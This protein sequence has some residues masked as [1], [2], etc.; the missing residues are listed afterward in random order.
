MSPSPSSNSATS[1]SP[2]PTLS[3]TNPSSTTH[4]TD[5]TPLQPQQ[6]L[7]FAAKLSSER[8]DSHLPN[9]QCRTNSDL[10]LVSISELSQTE[11]SDVSPTGHIKNV[12]PNLNQSIDSLRLSLSTLKSQHLSL[13]YSLKQYLGEDFMKELMNYFIERVNGKLRRQKGRYETKMKELEEALQEIRQLKERMGQ[14]EGDL[15]ASKAR[16]GELSHKNDVLDREMNGLEEQKAKEHDELQKTH[17]NYIDDLEKSHEAALEELKSKHLSEIQKM[18]EESDTLRNQI[19]EQ[20]K[21]HIASLASQK[22]NA[23]QS[24]E[25]ALE[26]NEKQARQQQEQA[27]SDAKLEWERTTL[28][29]SLDQINSLEETI[30]QHEI[31]LQDTKDMVTAI[32]EEQQTREIEHQEQLEQLQLRNS[33]LEESISKLEQKV[34]EQE[35]LIAKDARIS[36]IL[37][38]H[39]KALHSLRSQRNKWRRKCT[40]TDVIAQESSAKMEVLRQHNEKLIH[41]LQNHDISLNIIDENLVET[42]SDTIAILN[43]IISKLNTEVETL[44]RQK[45]KQWTMF[46]SKD[47][48]L[49]RV[50]ER[51]LGSLRKE[52]HRLREGTLLGNDSNIERTM[53]AV[54]EEKYRTSV[55]RIKKLETDMAHMKENRHED[56]RM[57]IQ[58]ITTKYRGKIEKLEAQL[59]ARGGEEKDK[60][61]QEKDAMIAFLNTKYSR[62]ERDYSK[63]VDELV[64]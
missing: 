14:I 57:A 53:L 10:S 1:T 6:T 59:G 38:R 40:E 33:E 41:L 54:F 45:K 64:R 43:R 30:A 24:L 29:P 58:R 15:E 16:E 44:E 52:I 20:Q 61:I 34:A 46:K 18:Q 26:E 50:H 2:T 23:Q 37:Q 39:E 28:Q 3:T 36:D 48:D 11:A 55:K 47:R 25:R 8:S 63:M 22:I 31:S 17:Q 21:A 9:Q 13:T 49:Q 51:E 32:T 5:S 56:I 27:L 12:P 60:L 7:H 4:Q 42:R 19:E 62:L 35:T